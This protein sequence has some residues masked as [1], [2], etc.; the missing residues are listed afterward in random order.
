MQISFDYGNK[1][2]V[3][4]NVDLLF[5]LAGAKMVFREVLRIESATQT[6]HTNSACIKFQF[7]AH[8]RSMYIL[9]NLPAFTSA[10]F[11]DVF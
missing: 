10:A 3:N 6:K 9:S 7:Y 2:L 4:S 11:L 8:V 1:H 5:E